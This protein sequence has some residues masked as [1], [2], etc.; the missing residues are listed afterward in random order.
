MASMTCTILDA[1][2]SGFAFEPRKP[3]V[4]PVRLKYR[5][6][7]WR[8]P[9]SAWAVVQPR[10]EVVGASVDWVWRHVAVFTHREDADAFLLQMAD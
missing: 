9:I 4:A 2:F 3:A 7:F 6:R 8:K 10:R 5:W 1:R